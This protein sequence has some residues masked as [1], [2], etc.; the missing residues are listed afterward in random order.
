MIDLNADYQ[1]LAKLYESANSLVYRA[2]SK[3]DQRSRSVRPAKSIILKILKENYPT[4]AE[5]ARYQ[6]EYELTRSL[7]V[8]GVIK[9]YGLQRHENSLVMLLED[10]DAQS[11][12]SLLAQQQFNLADF[13][14][15]AIKITESLAAIHTANIIHKDINPSNIVYNPQTGQLKIIDFG[16]ATRL[17]QAVL[18]I[19]PAHQ[20]EGTLAYIAPEQTGRMNRGIDYRSD[21]Y[22]LGVTFY[23]LLT[24]R[25]P[26]TTTDPMELVHCQIAQQPIPVNELVPN[27]PLVV[28]NII[29]KLLAKAPAA[30]YQSAW[31]LKIDLE[32]CYQ[33]LQTSGEIH[34]FGLGTQDVPE[35]M[36]IA[37]KLY[38]RELEVARLL[39]AFDQISAGTT[40][41][42]LITGLS[43]VGKSALVNQIQQ[44]IAR[45]CGQFIRGKFDLLDRDVP[46]AAIAQAFQDWIQRLLSE[47]ELELQAWKQ[48]IL[49]ALGT[50]AQ[51][52][53]DLMP[54]LEQII[55]AQ[56]PVE[57]LDGTQNQ[58]RFH[59]LFK[60]FLA[61]FCKS[62]H[63][64]VIFLD[65][66][67]WADLASLNLIE[68]LILDPDL[69]YFL[70]IGAY[71][72]NEVGISHPV[73]H[74]LGRMATAKIP[75]DQIALY[76]LDLSQIKLLIA[77]T[78]SCSIELTQPLAELLAH[79]T[80]GNPFFLTQLLYTLERENLLVFDR[81]QALSADRQC[82]WHW[83]IE[84][85]EQIAITDNVVDLMVAKIEKLDEQAQDVLKLAACI[86]NQFNL[87]TLAIV[88][89]QSLLATAAAL[90]PALA[91]NL[92]SNDQHFQQWD[93]T[94]LVDLDLAPTSAYLP[95]RPYRF[96]HD[97]VQQ[98]AY[99]L[100][101][102]REKG[103]VHLQIGRLLL[104][105]MQPAE[106]QV[107]IFEIVNHL[108]EGF[109]LIVEQSEKN[110][111]AKLNLQAGKK[112]KSA[113]AYLPALKYLEL[114]LDLLAEASWQDNYQITLELY[115]E[116][117][118]VFYLN[119][120]F[121][122]AQNLA[123]VVLAKA[124][125]LLDTVKV[126][127]LKINFHRS[128]F[129]LELAID[130]GLEFLHQLGL[131][132]P[133]QPSRKLVIAKQ[134][135]AELRL[136]VRQTNHDDLANL[137]QMTDFSQ[138][139]TIR[140][141]A[142]LLSPAFSTNRN[143]YH[144]VI[145]NLLDLHVE[146]GSSPLTPIAYGLYGTYLCEK[147][148]TIE[149]GYHFG[150]LSLEILNR[151]HTQSLRV[152]VMHSF[153]AFVKYWKEP[154][155]QDLNA[156]IAAIQIGIEHGEITFSNLAAAN[157]CYVLLFY[158]GSNLQFIAAEVAKYIDVFSKY[159]DKLGDTYFGFC[160]DF[161]LRLTDDSS[162]PTIDDDQHWLDYDRKLNFY[163]DNKMHGLVF[164]DII[165]KYIQ[166]Y[167]LKDY[168]RAA[169]Y[170]N[171]C[172]QR[173]SFVG[174][175]NL[176]S[177]HTF[178]ASLT[179]L[180]IVKNSSADQQPKILEKVSLNQQ[181][182]A[183]WAQISPENHQSK[184][185]LV[186]ALQAQLIGQNWQAAEL[187]EQAIQGAKKYNRTHE[188]ALAY[189]RAAE[190]Y[191]ELDR[192]EIGQL[193]LKNAYHCYSRWGATA[194]LKQLAA[195]YPQYRLG[196]IDR[197]QSQFS[198]TISHTGSDQILDLNTILKASQA[199]SGEIKLENLL[200]KLMQVAIENAGAQT[201][202]L[203]LE[204]DGRWVIAAEGQ[205]GIEMIKIKQS[206][207]IDTIDLDSQIPRLPVSI[208]NYVARTQASLVLNDA[209]HAGQFV[210]DPYIVAIQARSV[211]CIPLLDRGKLSGILYLENNLTADAF[212]PDRIE[213]LQLLSAQAAISLQNAQ[214]YVALHENERRLTQFLEAVPVGIAILDA[215]GKPY[216]AN[217]TAQQLLGKGLIKDAQTEQLREIYQ[218]YQA[219]TDQIYPS[220]TPIMRALN[221]ERTT[222]SDIE[223]HQTD[224]IIPIETCGTPVF[225][226]NGKVTYAISVFQDITQRKRAEAER[227]QFAQELALQN[228][229]L[230]RAR[231]EL[232]EYSRTLEQKVSERTQELSHTLGILKATQSELLF[233]N[234]L[235]RSAESPDT[236][237]Y[238]V[239][240]SLPMDAPTYVVRAADRHL[241]KALKH[242]E[243]CYV[244][245]PRQMGK[246]SLMVKMINHLQHE[247][248]CCASIDMTRIGS[249]TVTPEQ[250]YKGIASELVRCLD[251]RDKFNLKAWWQDQKD[252]SPVQRLSEFIES[253]VLV[254]VGT[255]A[256]PLVIFIDE[257]DSI[258]GLQ[259]SV[260]DFFALIRSCYNQ[261]SLNPKY[262]RLTFAFF[263]VASPAEL[264]TNTQITPFNIGQSI[265]LE[266]FKEHEAQPLLQGLVEKVTNPQTLLKEVLA[267]TSGQ[268]FLTQKLCKLIHNSIAI[269]S[270]NG[271]SAWIEQLVWS[272]I[273]DNWET[274]D[275]PEHLRTIRDRITKSPQSPHLLAL[276]Q[277]VL[278]QPAV[279]ITNSFT[280]R[281]LLLSG[282]VVKHQGLLIVQNRIYASVFN[283]DWIDRYI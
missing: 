115:L 141:L 116:T 29:G 192:A 267:W 178:Y 259:F 202:F 129:Q 163:V 245:N 79:K 40:E 135:Q 276:Y 282:I 59:L 21:F 268:P 252:L 130:S 11:L 113:N 61:V 1:I 235:L 35:K 166:L 14:T 125:N 277:L 186:A 152:M 232:A 127:E 118:E 10:F 176:I 123:D 132:L 26:F 188:E 108:N 23:E 216:Y 73:T 269:I 224:K 214:L 134:Q 143:L 174:A 181:K 106:I 187:Y 253:V 190:F 109:F 120:K 254:E 171:L 56:P 227:I 250:W 43:G 41:V 17:A 114:G 198:T 38:G 246:S 68:Q 225:D 28:A 12:K 101:P 13:L 37:S 158:A 16:I 63:P 184:F 205:I 196:V 70:I 107:K 128:Q 92:I 104:V 204:Q 193:Y 97:R 27:I 159:N 84:Q 220:L 226:D 95:D 264:I 66:L 149:L 144:L 211:L 30:R 244:L 98:A 150:R 121:D 240:G 182:M 111:L 117:L 266:G 200:Q 203:I 256:T 146:Y 160:R 133:K 4:P 42:I 257:I 89:N 77:D 2:T 19:S 173:K 209:T 273:I 64:L 169:E 283:K 199:I 31:G 53:I 105:N 153:H 222:V 9:T 185:D 110:N 99:S 262:Q 51:M 201:G 86:G 248:I 228:L 54:K 249:E 71:R 272:Q 154:G 189:E 76:P 48:Q 25:L 145:I 230:E 137:P 67:Q 85:I 265:Q 136:S 208:V 46:Y 96:L 177:Q 124:E 219:G 7:N 229:S 258:L 271:E 75:I 231:D 93:A 139:A 197:S 165:F 172:E 239:G 52:M 18:S 217:Q 3:T 233:E 90:Q 24:N 147:V 183:E 238:Q 155:S 279:T 34:H 140:I 164:F 88:N 179:L 83:N 194:K 142:K 157:Y 275:D 58:S 180:A 60:R 131:V 206:I 241:Y 103:Q 170:S 33:Q 22:A 74:L 32:A 94:D 210:R 78:L 87:A 57:P 168:I 234:E 223:I 50:N 82:Y 242:G 260:N 45:K 247:E 81:T 5:L 47:P 212:T 255:P 20:I 161:C 167:I 175:V 213:I 36:Q 280:E 195:E 15:I 281:E 69:K 138:F 8:D 49:L 119:G 100:I 218:L 126:Y 148:E 237:D 261:R 102:D 151:S 251:L 270:P 44:P 80:D 191:L 215:E 207:P 65:D 112:A 55:G 72:N 236:F 274:Q 122:R 6:Q 278:D 91:A 62:A 243:F 221:G 162:D 39:T 156:L 263:G